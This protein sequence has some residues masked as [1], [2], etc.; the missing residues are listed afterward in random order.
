VILLADRFYG[1]PEM[2]CWC[3]DRGWDYRLRNYPEFRA[4]R[5]G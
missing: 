3:C 4:R 5:G 2:I 1:T